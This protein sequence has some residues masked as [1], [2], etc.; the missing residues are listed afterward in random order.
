MNREI[1]NFFWGACLKKEM[2]P[3]NRPTPTKEGEPTPRVQC[4]P[5]SFFLGGNLVEGCLGEDGTYFINQN[6]AI[7]FHSEDEW[8]HYFSHVWRWKDDTF[9]CRLP[10]NAE[11]SGV[12]LCLTVE[13]FL[14]NLMLFYRQK[15]CPK[16]ITLF[17]D[18]CI[19]KGSDIPKI[20]AMIEAICKAEDE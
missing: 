14:N 19:T 17:V 11:K 9:M 16:F 4:V 8:M 5:F 18:E 10:R 1:F 13:T 12:M 6:T 20:Q 2:F 7:Q 15:D 3:K